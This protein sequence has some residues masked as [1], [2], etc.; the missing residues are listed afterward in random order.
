MEREPP[1][2]GL[3]EHLPGCPAG[4]DAMLACECECEEVIAAA[5]ESA[6]GDS[7]VTREWWKHKS[8]Q[9]IGKLT[10]EERAKIG[11]GEAPNLHD[12]PRKTT[13]E[14]REARREKKRGKYK[15]TPATEDEKKAIRAYARAN[16]R[17]TFGQV[18]GRFRRTYEEID[19][20]VNG[21]AR[22]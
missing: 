5:K 14:R 19:E 1:P 15:T 17:P 3:D 7:S 8:L 2:A 13:K 22:R 10:R 20:I 16:P 12:E 21:R 18:M 11:Y 9:W 6:K 4:E